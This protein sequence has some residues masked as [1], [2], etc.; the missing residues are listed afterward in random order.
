M[1]DP[2]VVG[3]ERAL[4]RQ[5][6][7]QVGR[8]ACAARRSVGVLVL[9]HDDEDVVDVG[10]FARR[11]GPAPGAAGR[12]DAESAAAA[13][14]IAPVTARARTNPWLL[15]RIVR[16]SICPGPPSARRFPVNLDGA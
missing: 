3:Q 11:A 10:Q 15:S 7:R 2:V 12:S 8:G 6:L 9:E 16:A 4:A 13:S 14:A 1:A 5:R